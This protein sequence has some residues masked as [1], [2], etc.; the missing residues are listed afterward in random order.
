VITDFHRDDRIDLAAIDAN[1]RKSGF[2]TFKWI[3]TDALSGKGGQLRIAY[4]SSGNAFLQ[5]DTDGNGK[6]DFE[7]KMLGV[8]SFNA[9][10]LNLS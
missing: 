4:R 5:G 8:S 10:N 2:Q 9:G 6:V 7:V 3:G 1:N